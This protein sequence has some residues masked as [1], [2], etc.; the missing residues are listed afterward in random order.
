MKYSPVDSSE[1]RLEET[2]SRGFI[3]VNC[4]LKSADIG[5]CFCFLRI[6]VA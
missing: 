1:I 4:L 3:F 5:G 6:F 2:I